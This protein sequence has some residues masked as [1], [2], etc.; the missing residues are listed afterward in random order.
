MV[1]QL[2]HTWFVDFFID[3]EWSWPYEIYELHGLSSFKILIFEFV[4]ASLGVSAIALL[5]IEFVREVRWFWEESQTLPKM[6]V[7][8]SIDLS[9]CLIHQKLQ[10]VCVFLF[11][12][13]YES[14]SMS[15]F[16]VNEILSKL[17]IWL[18]HVY[19]LAICIEKKRKVNEEDQDSVDSDYAS[20]IDEDEV[21][22]MPELLILVSYLQ[23]SSN[24]LIIG[25][26]PD[27]LIT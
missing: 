15:Y 20:I 17:M 18:V 22:K 11:I 9:T 4:V 23:T 21:V 14:L 10:M 8:S 27:R 2:Q 26:Y 6:P 5:W 19:Q 7:S 16:R 3:E 24:T 1:W 12:T 13:C 25:R